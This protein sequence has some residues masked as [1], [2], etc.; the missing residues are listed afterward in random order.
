MTH[1]PKK[2]ERSE[3]KNEGRSSVGGFC[4]V[5]GRAIG[6]FSGLAAWR[7]PHCWKTFCEDCCLIDSVFGGMICRECGTELYDVAYAKV[8]YL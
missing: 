1:I 6:G 4:S 3:R 2:R 5:C 7:C 8:G